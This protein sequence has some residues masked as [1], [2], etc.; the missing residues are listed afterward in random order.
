MAL[1]GGGGGGW[2][3]TYGATDEGDDHRHSSG[4]PLASPP[5]HGLHGEHGPGFRKV[6]TKEA[7]GD[8]DYGL[9]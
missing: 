8:G 7:P 6:W 4:V 3:A 5:Y 9:L 1:V 2:A